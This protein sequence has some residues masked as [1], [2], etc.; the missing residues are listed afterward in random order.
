MLQRNKKIVEYSLYGLIVF[1]PF[2]S[3]LVSLTGFAWISLLRDL[4][5]LTI[6][7]FAF[8]LREEKKFISSYYLPVVLFV[9]WTLL[10]IFWR[11]ASLSQWLKGV[12][13]L[14]LPLLLFISLQWVSLYAT[15]KNNINKLIIFSSIVIVTF[16]V[17]ELIGVKIPLTTAL[18]GSG[19]LVANQM[20]G[21]LGIARIGSIL[22]G[23]NA[24]GLYLL[25]M[26]ALSLNASNYFGKKN[27]L[28]LTLI[29]SF[30]LILTFSRSALIGLILL[31]LT[32]LMI[33]LS[34]KKSIVYSAIVGLF[35]VT[36]LSG[37]SFVLYQN[38]KTQNFLTHFSSSSLRFEQYQ[39]IW[40]QRYEIGLLGRGAGT[41]GPSSQVRLDGGENHW[42]ENVY[43]DIFEEL[44]LIGF[45]LYVFAVLS[46]LILNCRKINVSNESK[47][48]F[49]LSL[50]F[51]ITGIFINY[52]TGQ[53]A[54][55]LFWL[56]NGLALKEQ[57]G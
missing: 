36:L 20:V 40:N 2:S 35:V 55:F 13:L 19:A 48:A 57:Y 5:V 9:V 31:F 11:E 49:L 37:A 21:T 33:Q 17:L 53:V 29:Y 30:L 14:I 28:I 32:L 18:S 15:V 23:P 25:V 45:S 10:S 7:V 12:R 26:A 1:L 54:I 50:S 8:F 34:R 27:S 4:F 52:Y 44:G 47:I 38:P 43:L 42:T 22:A 3:W 24:L 56:I 46:A 6:F 41:A 16:A 51:L 39:R